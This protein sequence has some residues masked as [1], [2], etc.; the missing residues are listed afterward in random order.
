MQKDIT[1]ILLCEKVCWLMENK[2]K[3]ISEGAADIFIVPTELLTKHAN[4]QC[5]IKD[6]LLRQFM[7]L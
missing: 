6:L 2:I 4:G 1:L 3:Y 5:V 7:Q